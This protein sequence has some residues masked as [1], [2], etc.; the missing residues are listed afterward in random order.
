MSAVLFKPDLVKST[1]ML[2]V[3]IRDAALAF[4]TGGELG[5]SS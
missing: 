1:R 4:L 3:N 5:C 2:P